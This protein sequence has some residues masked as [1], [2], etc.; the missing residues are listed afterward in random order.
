MIQA[1]LRM[2]LVVLLGIIALGVSVGF[3][4]HHV[5]ASLT[6]EKPLKISKAEN[7]YRIIAVWEKAVLADQTYQQA[8]Q[9]RNEAVTAWNAAVDEIIQDEKF[10]KGTTFTVNLDSQDVQV[11]KPPSDKPA[12]GAPVPTKK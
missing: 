3:G 11:V 8:L 7:K 10:P 6:A 4:V 1:F 2:R 12:A 9:K 5:Y